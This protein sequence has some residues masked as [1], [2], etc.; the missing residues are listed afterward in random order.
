[1]VVDPQSLKS[2]GHAAAGHAGTMSDED[3][4]LFIKPCVQ[5]E[6]DFYETAKRDHPELSD[7][8]PEYMGTLSLST[9]DEASEAVAAVVS[10]NDNVKTDKDQITAA[11]SKQISAGNAAPETAPA[12]ENE[13]VPTKGGKISTNKAVV[14][15]NNTYGFKK[16]NILDVKLGVRLWA[17]DAPEKKKAKF[18]KISE[19]TTHRNFGFRI[20]GMRMYKGSDN[21]ADLDDEDY[22][23]YDK[24]YGRFA[25]N[26]NNLVSEFRHFV[27][28]KN[29]G[30]DKELGQAVCKA[31]VQTVDNVEE[32]LSQ[33][34]TRMYSASLLFVFEGDG[35]ALR[36]A[37]EKNN[38][39]VDSVSDRLLTTK[40]VDSGIA[41]EDE[42]SDE[43]LTESAMNSLPPIFSVKL[44]DFAHATWVPGQGPDENMLKG[45]RS[46]R[47]I[48]QT[49]ATE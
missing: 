24:D 34:E 44:I 31:F 36:S 9:L 5:A 11:V 16:P 17:D 38:S 2:Y 22:R 7:L 46:V 23:V 40:R 19:E 45:V 21:P 8:M 49:L 39:I 15:V 48:F 28:N 25:V 27:F 14:L 13:W 41:I 26:D 29:A 3:G 42:E 6:I 4:K 12:A 35:K 37:I 10:D 33:N 18:D 20:A 30:I 1:M 32:V 47:N 43:D